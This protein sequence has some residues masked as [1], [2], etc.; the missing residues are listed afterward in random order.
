MSEVR[1]KDK[2][3]SWEADESLLE[4]LER[5]G[6]DVPSFVPVGRVPQLPGE[7]DEGPDQPDRAAGPQRNLEA[8][9]DVHVVRLRLKPDSPFPVRAGQ[10]INLTRADGLTRSYSVASREADGHV[11]LHVRVVPNGKMSEWVD[12]ELALGHPVSI[13]GRPAT[14]STSTAAPTNHCC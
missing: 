3:F 12:R 8:A 5:N 10:F 11:E 1:F 9:A 6:V 4:L 2:K 14:A 13:R 7:G